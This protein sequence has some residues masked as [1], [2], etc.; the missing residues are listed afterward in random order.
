MWRSGKKL[1]PEQRDSRD[2]DWVLEAKG[3]SADT[4]HP[5]VPKP[6]KTCISCEAT[7]ESVDVKVMRVGLAVARLCSACST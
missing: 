3:R 2:A 1:K 5:P 4:C 7:T 6:H